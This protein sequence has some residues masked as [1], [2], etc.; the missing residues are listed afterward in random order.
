MKIKASIL[1]FIDIYGDLAQIKIILF[2]ISGMLHSNSFSLG[3]KVI[4]QS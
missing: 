2:M 3:L 4:G 1:D